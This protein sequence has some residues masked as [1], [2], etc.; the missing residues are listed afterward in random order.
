MFLSTSAARLRQK[1]N[2]TSFQ[3]HLPEKSV[4]K[5]PNYLNFK[6]FATIFLYIILKLH[7]GYQSQRIQHVKSTSIRRRK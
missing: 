2:S 7:A 4:L 1:G 5:I 6:I 3:K